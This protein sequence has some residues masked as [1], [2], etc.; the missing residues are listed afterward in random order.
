D[1]IDCWRMFRSK[2]DVTYVYP[3]TDRR[4]LEFIYSAPPE[5]HVQRGRPRSLFRKAMT[6][7]VPTELLSGGTKIEGR[8]EWFSRF[9]FA[10]QVAEHLTRLEV[11]G[12]IE[13]HPWVDMMRLRE[14][15]M[16][17]QTDALPSVP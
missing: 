15:L 14:A 13:P 6:P 4:V 12:S 9:S 11:P 2:H 8:R 17:A 3:L 1:R 16:G 5:L 7:V 10:D